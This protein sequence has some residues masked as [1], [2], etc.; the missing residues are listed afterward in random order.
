MKKSTRKKNVTWAM[1]IVELSDDRTLENRK[2][3]VRI[4]R[5]FYQTILKAGL[6]LEGNLRQ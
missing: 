4:D 6:L 3:C 1:I 2:Q 5:I